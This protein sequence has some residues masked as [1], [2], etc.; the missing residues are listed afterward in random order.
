MNKLFLRAKLSEA[1]SLSIFV[2]YKHLD[3]FSHL[4]SLDANIEPIDLINDIKYSTQIKND[5]LI[6]TSE[7]NK[8]KE[9]YYKDEVDCSDFIESI[10]EQL[11]E[12]ENVEIIG[13]Y[14][15]LGVKSTIIYLKTLN[16]TE[17]VIEDTEYIIRYDN[18]VDLLTNIFLYSNRDLKEKKIEYSAED[19]EIKEVFNEQANMNEV[20]F[21]IENN[22]IN[23]VLYRDEE[24]SE[25]YIANRYIQHFTSVISSK[26][27]TGD[28]IYEGS[29]VGK[30]SD[31]TVHVFVSQGESLKSYSLLN[32]IYTVVKINSQN[33]FKNMTISDY[34]DIIE[35]ELSISKDDIY[36]TINGMSFF[37]TL[38][39]NKESNI[40]LVGID[41]ILKEK[42][43]NDNFLR[44]KEKPVSGQ[45]FIDEIKMQISKQYKEEEEEN[46]TE[47]VYAAAI[48]Q[49]GVTEQYI[50]IA[51][52]YGAIIGVIIEQKL[53]S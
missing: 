48:L 33:E 51:D 5:K 10:I 9:T 11:D 25:R 34:Y 30:N 32:K 14:T 28:P 29:F 53:L 43:K 8:D 20:Q 2:K 6:F 12:N 40:D 22:K 49:K 27:L 21:D 26:L 24:F 41:L 18:N 23:K 4:V 42:F 44:Y 39:E 36:M 35:G 15:S 47:D 17:T 7:A 1:D 3:F 31:E 16:T 37:S 45:D 50:S 38:K 19:N 46:K 13:R 52:I